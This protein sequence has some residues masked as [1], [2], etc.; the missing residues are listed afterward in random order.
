MQKSQFADA[1][2]LNVKLSSSGHFKAHISTVRFRECMRCELLDDAAPTT[3][4]GYD[5]KWE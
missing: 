5:K 2:T 4:V 3:R 1:K